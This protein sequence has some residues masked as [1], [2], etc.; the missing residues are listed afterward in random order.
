MR[1][2]IIAAMDDTRLIGADN[3]LPWHIPEDLK[4]FKRTTTGHVMVMGSNTWESFGGRALPNRHHVIVT[5]RDSLTI[6]PDDA[7]R[8][9]LANNLE[10]AIT[11]AKKEA[12]ARGQEEVF[13]IGGANLYEQTIGMAD[14][15]ILTRVHGAFEGDKFFPFFGPEWAG[16]F[17]SEE[18]QLLTAGP[19]S[20]S[21]YDYR[22]VHAGVHAL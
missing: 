10:L 1:L 14:R 4:H 20:Y 2:T 16:D 9:T 11:E 8:V 17:L 6:H 5:S 13:L 15:M 7:D 12:E 3:G 18:S 19:I 21:I 22:R